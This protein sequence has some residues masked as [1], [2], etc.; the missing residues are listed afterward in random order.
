MQ[1]Q[2]S[3]PDWLTGG[4]TCT[5]GTSSTRE[6]SCSGARADPPA[7]R[8]LLGSIGTIGAIGAIGDCLYRQLAARPRGRSER[9][10]TLRLLRALGQPPPNG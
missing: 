4:V 2:L 7:R 10:G 1:V 6:G 3:R 8:R 9:D 5:T